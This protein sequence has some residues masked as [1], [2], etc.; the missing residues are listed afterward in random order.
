MSGAGREAGSEA[1][2]ASEAST[3]ASTDVSG[4]A[5]SLTRTVGPRRAPLNSSA[6]WTGGNTR[7][8]GVPMVHPHGRPL[9]SPGTGV[10]DLEGLRRVRLGS[11]TLG[12]IARIGVVMI[13]GVTAPMS[14]GTWL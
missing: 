14:I 11:L 2:Q 5:V 9:E 1:G 10:A 12:R 6:R 8:G 4:D 13:A 7:P 3:H